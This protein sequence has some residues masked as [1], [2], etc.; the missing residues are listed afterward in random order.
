MTSRSPRAPVRSGS[1]KKYATQ[2]ATSVSAN[3]SSQSGHERR[4]ERDGVGAGGD[5]RGDDD[6]DESFAREVHGSERPS[7]R[8][9][10]R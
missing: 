7:G 8:V 10:C 2:S 6:E 9:A 4:V 3:A 1:R 5:Q